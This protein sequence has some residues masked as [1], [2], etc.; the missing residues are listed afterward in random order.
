MRT[1][2][3]WICFAAALAA[4]LLAGCECSH[5]Y[6]GGVVTKEAAC[7]EEGVRTYTCQKC[8]ESYQ[9]AI[10]A[11]EH[12]YSD[13]VTK[14]PTYEEEGV[15]TFTCSLCRDSYT[16]AIPA[17]EKPVAVTV[18]A[19]RTGY[20]YL[21]KWVELDFSVENLTEADVRGFQGEL[22]ARD[23]FGKELLSFRCQFID[24]FPDGETVG[25]ET[26]SML[27][28][29][30]DEMEKKF[31]ETPL[32]DLQ[33]FYK[34][35]KVVFAPEEPVEEKVALEGPVTITVTSIHPFI[36]TPQNRMIGS[37]I[38]LMLDLDNNT[39]KEI[40]GIEGNLIFRNMFGDELAEKECD[41]M[42]SDARTGERGLWYLLH[43]DINDFSSSETTILYTEF[44]DLNFEYSLSSILF[45]DGTQKFFQTPDGATNL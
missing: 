44:R 21:F 24:S 42:M 13:R 30:Y 23:V 5:E 39:G 19:K 43:F 15:R 9:E 8:G 10:P 14:E 45:E 32:S 33:F 41:L 16:E 25:E 20:N 6:D 36:A 4:L 31:Y 26:L 35:E 7:L 40:K 38:Q 22:V 34:L 18:T 28:D 27:I 3:R 12:S 17:L 1:R 11:L 29:S 2:T 37:G